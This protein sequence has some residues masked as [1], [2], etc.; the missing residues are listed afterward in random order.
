MLLGLLGLLAILLAA[1]GGTSARGVATTEGA[2]ALVTPP[3][4]ATGTPGIGTPMP[5]PTMMPGMRTPMPCGTM[6]PGMGTPMPCPTGM[7]PCTPGM[8]APAAL[9]QNGQYS[10]ERFI[11][12][13]VPHHLMAI[14]MAQLAQ[15]QGQHAQIKQLAASIITTQTKEINELKALKQRLYGTSMT[16]TMMSSMQMD[17]LGMLTPDQLAHQHP[18]DEALIDSMISHHVSAINMASVALLR[19]SNPDIKRI[20]RVIVDAQ[21]AEIGQMIQWRQAWYRS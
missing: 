3:P 15:K 10:D 21:S 19:S 2:V 6:M 14:Q 17:N 18:F 7:G 1:M 4:G 8:V 13:M 16:P 20:A 5:C 11:D 12:M 9:V